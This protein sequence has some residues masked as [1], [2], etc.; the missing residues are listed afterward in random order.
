MEASGPAVPL[1]RNPGMQVRERA[2]P[3]SPGLPVAAADADLLEQ[4]HRQPSKQR[5]KA[6][7]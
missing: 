3:C 6:S 4:P 1:A 2:C 7:F 5:R